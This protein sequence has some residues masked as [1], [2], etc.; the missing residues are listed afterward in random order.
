MSKV[1]K[2][3]SSKS[4]ENKNF[5]RPHW[6]FR[7]ICWKKDCHTKNITSLKILISEAF[8]EDAGK[9]ST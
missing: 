5:E 2:N 1:K 8:Q 9:K 6:F 7:M 3:K 4:T